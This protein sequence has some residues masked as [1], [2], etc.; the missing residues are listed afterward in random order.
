MVV[1]L[2]LTLRATIKE[3]SGALNKDV[4][5]LTYRPSRN[6]NGLSLSFFTFD[7][8]S[9]FIRKRMSSYDFWMFKLDINK[10]L[11]TMKNPVAEYFKTIL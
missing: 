11:L 6:I 5:N 1:I 7:Y 9:V 2:T 3:Q 10:V 8:P 4:D